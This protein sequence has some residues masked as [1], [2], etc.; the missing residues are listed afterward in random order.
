[1][2]LVRMVVARLLK[3]TGINVALRKKWTQTLA[4]AGVVILTLVAFHALLCITVR[5]DPVKVDCVKVNPVKVDSV[6]VDPVKV[7]EYGLKPYP[8]KDGYTQPHIVFVLAD[9]Y[10]YRDV[11]YHGSRIRTPN[12]DRLAAEGVRMENYYVQHVCTPTRSQLISGRYQIHTGR[13]MH[14]YQVHTGRATH[15]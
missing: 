5:T 15:R 10:G 8:M 14:R 13:A 7:A 3:A 12:L 9:D 4:L 6:K 2:R 11:G 1:M